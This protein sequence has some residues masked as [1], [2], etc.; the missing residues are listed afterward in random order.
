MLGNPLV[1]FCEGRGGN[2]FTLG[3]PRLLDH[4]PDPEPAESV[5]IPRGVK[6]RDVS[7]GEIVSKS[8][9]VKKR[10]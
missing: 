7:Q 9:I 2:W 3:A 10:D 8:E 6:K 5:K 4:L 1:R